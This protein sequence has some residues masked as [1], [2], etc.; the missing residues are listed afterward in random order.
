MTPVVATPES[1]RGTER[2][3]TC[4]LNRGGERRHS[5][6]SDRFEVAVNGGLC[7][8][9]DPHSTLDA[10]WKLMADTRVTRELADRL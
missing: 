7:S 3:L 2:L 4:R 5:D 1:G 9:I 8:G 6:A 10:A